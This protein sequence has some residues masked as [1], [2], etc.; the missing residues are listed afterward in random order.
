MNKLEEQFISTHAALHTVAKQAAEAKKALIESY[1]ALHHPNTPCQIEI[2]KDNTLSLDV[3]F[4]GLNRD[5]SQQL[6]LEIN[7]YLQVLLG[8]AVTSHVDTIP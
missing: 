7:S 6:A 5:N 3:V 8:D 2:M 1:V 4:P